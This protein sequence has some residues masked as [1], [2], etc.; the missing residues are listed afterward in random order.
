MPTGNEEDDPPPPAP[1][2]LPSSRQWRCRSRPAPLAGAPVVRLPRLTWPPR[3]HP[4]CPATDAEPP[5]R[6]GRRGRQPTA[7]KGLLAHRRTTLAASWAATRRPG[8]ALA[9]CAACRLLAWASHATAAL[10]ACSLH[11]EPQQSAASVPERGQPSRSHLPLRQ[12]QARDGRI[13]P[14]GHRIR[15]LPTPRC[16]G[17]LGPCW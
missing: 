2:A 11:A 14:L 5:P 10:G 9:G 13:Q 3:W 16:R 12:I 8:R 15:R 17:H 7:C 6:P 1:F 4:G